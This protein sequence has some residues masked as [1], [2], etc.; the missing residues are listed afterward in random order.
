[1]PVRPLSF[2]L[3]KKI[4]LHIHDCT[5]VHTW[6]LQSTSTASTDLIHWS[7]FGGCMPWFSQLLCGNLCF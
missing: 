2:A 7:G 5:H 6:E 3:S 4:L 1:M